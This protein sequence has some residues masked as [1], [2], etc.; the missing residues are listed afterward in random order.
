MS[1]PGKDSALITRLA[2]QT[3]WTIV[4]MTQSEMVPYLKA[5]ALTAVGETERLRSRRRRR[6]P[7]RS[8]PL[9]SEREERRPR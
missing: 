9:Q 4:G 5:M 1:N 7:R 3:A 2:Q 6:K 8:V